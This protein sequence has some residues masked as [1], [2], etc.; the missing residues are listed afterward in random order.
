MEYPHPW[1]SAVA[2]VL[3]GQVELN[4]GRCEAA[5][6]DILAAERVLAEVGERWGTAVTLSSLATLAGWRGE[7]A[8][9]VGYDERAPVLLTELGSAEDEVQARLNLAHQL[10]LAGGSERGR[11]RAELARRCATRRLGLPEVM[12][13]PQYGWAHRPA[14]GG[15]G[16]GAGADRRAARRDRR[17]RPGLPGQLAA[18]IGNARDTWTAAA[19]D[20]ERRARL[21]RPGGADRAGHRGRAGHRPGA[22]RAGR[23]GDARGRPGAGRHAAGC[24]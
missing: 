20:L 21:P 16:R 9:A 5:E 11:S 7:Y 23:S 3:R 2:R 14:G 12:A 19:G 17:T 15:P 8:A 24:E 1:I 13:T 18:M 10:W 22:G 6:A 4:V